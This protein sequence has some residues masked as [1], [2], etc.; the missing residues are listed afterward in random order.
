MDADVW[1]KSSHCTDN[2]CIE[3]QW[4]TS[5]LCATDISCVE[6]G[7]AKVVRRDDDEVE[8]CDER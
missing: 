6:V 7:F 3:V 4:R 5:S 1:T 2:A 8:V